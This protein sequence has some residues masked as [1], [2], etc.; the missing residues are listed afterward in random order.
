MSTS[1]GVKLFDPVDIHLLLARRILAAVVDELRFLPRTI[2]L[3]QIYSRSRSTRRSCPRV[4]RKV[5]TEG[6]ALSFDVFGARSEA[7]EAKRG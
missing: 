2:A 1:D 5:A 7:P 3:Y 6:R 4:H